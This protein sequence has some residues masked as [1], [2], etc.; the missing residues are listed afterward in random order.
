V[1]AALDF[2]FLAAAAR[3]QIMF[4]LESTRVPGIASPYRNAFVGSS[5]LIGRQ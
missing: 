2:A 1:D 3:Y 5:E 4:G